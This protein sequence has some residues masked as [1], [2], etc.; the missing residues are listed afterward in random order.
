MVFADDA[1]VFTI[2]V[3]ELSVLLDSLDKAAPIESDV[4]V[5]GTWLEVGS[6]WYEVVVVMTRALEVIV[7]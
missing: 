1:V 6:E 4:T 2:E 3:R 5:P 7:G